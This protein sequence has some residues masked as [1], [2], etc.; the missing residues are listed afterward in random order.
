MNFKL[1]NHY[2]ISFP[3]LTWIATI[4]K[5]GTKYIE[6]TFWT[7]TGGSG[8]DYYGNTDSTYWSSAKI[9]TTDQRDC[10][11]NIWCPKSK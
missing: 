10:L 5:I 1:G 4:D 2:L 6:F 7:H 11:I 9:I 3:N 8:H